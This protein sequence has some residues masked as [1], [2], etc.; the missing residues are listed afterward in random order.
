MAKFKLK[1]REKK[2]IRESIRL[3]NL[4][5]ELGLIKMEMER[6]KNREKE[7]K[8]TLL[9]RVAPGD[10]IMGKEFEAVVYE[11]TEQIWDNEK[12]I[13]RFP[14]RVLVEICKVTAKVKEYL[15]PEQIEDY[16]VDTKTDV[17]IRINK[18]KEVK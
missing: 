13:K 8:E 18:R 17:R 9:E 3:A 7:I 2:K 10:K 4:V 12:V 5:D 15:T 14:K 6:L 1:E 16:V 11:H